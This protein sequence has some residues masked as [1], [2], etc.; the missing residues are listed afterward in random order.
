MRKSERLWNKLAFA[1]DL[2][3]EAIPGLPLVELVSN[4]RVLIENHNGVCE[5][6]STMIR[7]KVKYGSVSICG[8]KLELSRMDRGRLIVSGVIENIQ[9][10]RE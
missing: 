8:Q 7:I 2:T 1:A 9:L 3:D 4:C 5:Y 6:G 10:C